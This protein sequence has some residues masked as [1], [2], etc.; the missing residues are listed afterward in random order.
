MQASNMTDKAESYQP[1]SEMSSGSAPV[2]TGALL[3]VG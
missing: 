2:D 3:L 1:S